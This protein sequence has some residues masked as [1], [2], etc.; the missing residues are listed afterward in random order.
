MKQTRGLVELVVDLVVEDAE[1]VLLAQRLVGLAHVERVASVERRLVGVERAAPR[2]VPREQAA[3]RRQ[4]IGL[5]G[6]RRRALVGGVRGGRPLRDEIPAVVRLGVVGLDRDIGVGE[7]VDRVLRRRGHGGGRE[8]G[9]DVVFA[10]D[11]GR[12]GRLAQVIRRLAGRLGA[13]LARLDLQR[14]GK[15]HRVARHVLVEVGP[16]LGG[17][18]RAREKEREEDGAKSLEQGDP[19]GRFKAWS[20][21][22]EPDLHGVT[23]VSYTTPR[24]E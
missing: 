9:G 20:E 16:D 6:R 4:R 11:G 18:G 2:A 23:P 1:A 8:S 15:P 12:G 24:L 19:R 17:E 7:P 21:S 14:L 13:D 5:G 3:E 10:G 22:R